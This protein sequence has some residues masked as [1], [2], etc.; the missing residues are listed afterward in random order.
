MAAGTKTPERRERAAALAPDDR[1]EA[2]VAATTP[3][4]LEHGLNVTTRQIAEAAGI[5]EGTVFRAFADKDALLDAVIDR[6][7]DQGPVEERLRAI[8]P[9]LDFEAQLTE[10]VL[11]LHERAA[12]V[13]QLVSSVGFRRPP[14]GQAKRPR[15]ALDDLAALVTILERHTDVLRHDAAS[16]ARR[17]RALTVAG[18]NA[19]VMGGEPMSPEDTVELF[20]DGVRRRSTGPG[21]SGPTER[22]AGPSGPAERDDEEAQPCS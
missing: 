16:N 20:L 8:D 12:S 9:S 10:A 15:P 22:K 1:R 19:T 13:W 4:V 7:L 21:P 11:I 17:L 6:V 3:L 5:A 14:A 2:I 18:A